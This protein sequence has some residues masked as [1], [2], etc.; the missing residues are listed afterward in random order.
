MVDDIPTP[1]LED[2]Q[3]K[4]PI[5]RLGKPEELADAVVWLCSDK[6]SFVT[7][8]NM[9]IDGGYTLSRVNAPK[10]RERL[11]TIALVFYI[12]TLC[13]WGVTKIAKSLTESGLQPSSPVDKS[14]VYLGLKS[15][16]VQQERRSCP[17]M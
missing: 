8:H 1:L 9:V 7:G 10:R 17:G 2:I 15:L 14:S 16:T 3:S 6:A 11:L 12:S 13:C 4:H 5:G